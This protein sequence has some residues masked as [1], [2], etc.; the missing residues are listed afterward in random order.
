M[1]FCNSLV[2]GRSHQF[3]GSNH[4][5]YITKEHLFISSD[6][7]AYIHYKRTS[8]LQHQRQ[9]QRNISSNQLGFWHQHQSQQTSQ[10]KSLLTQKPINLLLLLLQ[11]QLILMSYFGSKSSDLI[12]LIL[13]QC[14]LLSW[15]CFQIPNNC[16]FLSQI[17]FQT[18]NSALQ[19]IV[20]SRYI[21]QPC[22]HNAN[23]MLL[24][25]PSS[26]RSSG[27]FHKEYQIV[28]TVQAEIHK[29]ISNILHR[30]VHIFPL[31]VIHTHRERERERLSI[32]TKGKI[33]CPTQIR[34]LPSHVHTQIKCSWHQWY[35]LRFGL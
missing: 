34:I 31:H 3:I 26:S 35:T 5:T 33:T 8:E 14:I 7:H 20:F 2:L 13:K 24:K 22:P 12:I 19:P 15:F 23:N 10:K 25:K 28:H 9:S 1:F 32:C 4:Q 29:A 16:I 18:T 30:N 17:C 21:L 6:H 11:Q 27:S